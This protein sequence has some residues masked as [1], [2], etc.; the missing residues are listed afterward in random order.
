MGV[1]AV[2][3]PVGLRANAPLPFAGWSQ[4]EKSIKSIAWV[5]GVFGNFSGL[6]LIP[7]DKEDLDGR[8]LGPSHVLVCP[9][10]SL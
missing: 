7:P 6:P 9:H 10:H 4:S 1:E 3:G 8:E 2:S 5:T